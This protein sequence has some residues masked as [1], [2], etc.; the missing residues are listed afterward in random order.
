[1][2]YFC[3]GT[4]FSFSICVYLKHFVC[5]M[6]DMLN[7]S[8]YVCE[9]CTLFSVHT[10]VSRKKTTTNRWIKKK[11][12]FSFAFSHSIISTCINRNAFNHNIV[13]RIQKKILT[14]VKVGLKLPS[15]D[16]RECPIL[17]MIFVD[18]F[19]QRNIVERK[20]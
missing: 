8:V 9:T 12:L 5:R 18:F 13:C 1:M 6:D 14:I 19:Q 11:L 17:L 16:K 4:W 7:V 15:N 10:I 20:K 2:Y 3:F